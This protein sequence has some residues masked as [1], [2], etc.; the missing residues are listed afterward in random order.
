MM[1]DTETRMNERRTL[2]E[3]FSRMFNE[4]ELRTFFAI[5][6][7]GATSS[8]PGLGSTMNHLVM[9]AVTVLDRFGMVEADLFTNLTEFRPDS[10][11]E[12]AEIA[13]MIS[14]ERDAHAGRDAIAAPKHEL[15]DELAKVF[16]DREQAAALLHRVGFPRPLTPAFSN[17]FSYWTKVLE[18]IEHGAPPGRIRSLA[19][20]AAGLY[21]S[22][23]VF[24]RHCG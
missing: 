4:S 3:L 16:G 11:V 21:P 10:R 14:S 1:N 12:V 24:G 2:F 22:N 6:Y 19:R 5:F 8:L 18:E 15:V 23:A 20:V 13:A 17:P 7:P 9:E